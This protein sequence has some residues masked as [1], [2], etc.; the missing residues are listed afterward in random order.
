MNGEEEYPRFEYTRYVQ[1][2]AP[3]PAAT[4]AQAP[5]VAAPESTGMPW[6]MWLL[7]ALLALIIIIVIAVTVY[8]ST[9]GDASIIS[10]SNAMAYTRGA[11]SAAAAAVRPP[12]TDF[13][14]T[15]VQSPQY[16]DPPALS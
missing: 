16:S 3:K 13:I 14:R 8:M 10:G 7:I 1:P 11:A 9:H 6:Y 12:L 5:A 15:V 2:Q 4:A